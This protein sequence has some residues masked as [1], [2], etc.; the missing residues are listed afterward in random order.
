[1]VVEERDVQLSGPELELAWRSLRLQDYPVVLE[2]LSHGATRSE[3]DELLGAAR[4]ALR[5]RGLW[6]DHGPE[7]LLARYLQTLAVPDTEVDVRGRGPAGR[8]RGLVAGGPAATVL[9]VQR[10]GLHTL[11]PVSAG[12]MAAAVLSTLPDADPAAGQLNAPSAELH[13][14]FTTVGSD[15]RALGAVLRELGAS[16]ADA[17]ALA[18]ALPTARGSAQIGAAARSHGPRRRAPRVVAL[19]D[20]DVGRYLVIETRSRDRQPWTTYVPATPVRVHAAVQ[21]LLATVTGGGWSPASR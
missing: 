13:R 1:M 10:D 18:R 8:W 11:T 9:V 16:A 19:L 15:E 12:S 3:R 6:D 14:A 5:E 2:L 21:E 20:T 7:P 4:R 17:G